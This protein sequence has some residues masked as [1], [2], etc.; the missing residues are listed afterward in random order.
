VREIVR[1][2]SVH[3]LNLAAIRSALADQAQPQ[4]GRDTPQPTPTLGPALRQLRKR[5]GM[6]IRQVSDAIG[7]S[8]STIST[9]ERTSRG[10]SVKVLKSLS[11]VLGTTLTE[12]ISS[13]NDR[14][15]AV[16]RSGEGRI[17]PMLGTGIKILELASGPRMMDCQE[18]YLQPGAESEGFYSHDGE[19]FIRLLSGEF[20]I[21]IEGI[22]RV[23]LRPGDSIHFESHRPHSWRCSGRTPCHLLWVNTPPTF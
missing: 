13:K 10:A 18:W 14:Q 22:G 7:I 4:N 5:R 8:A 19:E 23:V 9:L 2:R 20:E 1:L 6:T 12:I 15:N 21:E 3:G 16:V 17:L 11:E